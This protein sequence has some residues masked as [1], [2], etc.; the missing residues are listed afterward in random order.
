MTDAIPQR[1]NLLDPEIPYGLLIDAGRPEI[2]LIVVAG[3]WLLSLLFVGSAR[4]S[5]RTAPAA[6]RAGPVPA[7]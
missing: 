7:E 2:V 1:E 6:G 4:A 3:L 5:G